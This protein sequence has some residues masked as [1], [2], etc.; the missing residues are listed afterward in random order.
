MKYVAFL[1]GINVGGNTKIP[2][3]DLKKLFEGLGY[4]NV[5]TVLNSGNVVFDGKHVDENNIEENLEKK[6][7]FKISLI[8]RNEQE[9]KKLIKK[10]SPEKLT[11]NK[12]FYV[13]FI[14][15]KPEVC[16]VVDLNSKGTTD[17]MKD[18][19]KK[20]G[21]EITTRNWNTLLK[22]LLLLN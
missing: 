8:L 6:F 5:K 15:G 12:R 13:T 18:L 9:I 7:G 2:M 16:N 22:I 3:A 17:M 19:E 4:K 10:N 20:Y 11:P 14:K 21:K 1:R